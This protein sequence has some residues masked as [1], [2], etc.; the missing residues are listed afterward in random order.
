MKKLC[1]VFVLVFCLAACA[2]QPAEP[3]HTE[4]TLPQLNEQMTPQKLLQSAIDDLK[5]K[6]ATFTYGSGWEKELDMT[7][8]EDT[9]QLYALVPNE[10]LISEFCAMPLMA[11]PSNDGTFCYQA[12]DLTPLQ[13]CRVICGRD[14]TVEERD[15]LAVYPEAEGAVQI[16]VDAEGLFQSLQVD[17]SLSDGVWTLQ[18]V[19]E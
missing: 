3:I 14:L 17:V 10:E 1:I 18:I 5:G 12:T 4:P 9:E 13:I 15:K 8:A 19:R 16:K 2:E 7:A 11:I 6:N